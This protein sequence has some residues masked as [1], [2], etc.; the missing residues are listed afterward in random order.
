MSDTLGVLLISGDAA[1][2][3]HAFVVATGA[4]AIG[5]EVVLFATDAG[6]RALLADLSGFAAFDARATSCG[7]ATFAELRAAAFELGIR[8]IACEA[9]LRLAGIGDGLAA[10]VEVA[11]VVSFLAAARGQVITL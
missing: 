1:R 5:R 4:A 7:V 6:C 8:M 3:H 11:G 2:M 9:G 10:G